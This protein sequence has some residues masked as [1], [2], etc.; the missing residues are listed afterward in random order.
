MSDYSHSVS[1]SD[2]YRGG[3]D[4][5][6]AVA[7]LAD[8]L[9]AQIDAVQGALQ[10]L[11]SDALAAQLAEHHAGVH[12]APSHHGDVVWP[13]AYAHA[14]VYD[15]PVYVHTGPLQHQHHY[16]YEGDQ[17]AAQMQTGGLS[18]PS[19]RGDSGGGGNSYPNYMNTN[20]NHA[21]APPSAYNLPFSQGG[22]FSTSPNLFTAP[23]VS[24]TTPH[25]DAPYN[26]P[27]LPHTAASSVVNP[28]PRLGLYLKRAPRAPPPHDAIIA[29]AVDVSNTIV[30]TATASTIKQW[31]TA[32]RCRGVLRGHVAS[33]LALRVYDGCLY[34]SGSDSTLIRWPSAS[35][36][37]SQVVVSAT[38]VLSLVSDT[39]SPP[40]RR[41]ATV[42]NHASPNISCPNISATATS[43]GAAATAAA[44]AVPPPPAIAPA[45]TMRLPSP[46]AF[47]AVTVAFIFVTS[48]NDATCVDAVRRDGVV[49]V[50]YRGHEAP[51]TDICAADGGGR[52][53]GVSTYTHSGVRRSGCVLYTASE[54]A[55]VRV[56]NADNGHCVS[57]LR[58]HNGP[59]RSIQL[60]VT[61][62]LIYS[63]GDDGAVRVWSADGRQPRAGGYKSTHR[64]VGIVPALDL[65]AFAVFNDDTIVTA[66]A[67]SR[68][69]AE[70]DA[71]SGTLRR[72]AQ[73]TADTHERDVW[74]GAVRDAAATLAAAGGGI[75][76]FPTRPKDYAEAAAPLGEYNPRCTCGGSGGA[77]GVCGCVRGAGGPD[78]SPVH[79]C[80]VDGSLLVAHGTRVRFL[81]LPLE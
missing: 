51:V 43:A 63:G 59:V 45:Q 16:E 76:E 49:A 41:P 14:G 21:T 42:T 77:T 13:A 80:V 68:R 39:S 58:G 46:A 47:L 5:A 9:Q 17:H 20:Y 29:V 62:G 26:T 50:T 22:G 65:D 78:E 36:M 74:D 70:W 56:W 57:V 72:T 53:N 12:P 31:T 11:Q 32:G 37:G 25:T 69:L 27:S 61:N 55:T 75:L 71:R 38:G 73:L 64:C 34:S 15:D 66:D 33:V 18:D 24:I 6:T 81:R 67:T 52:Y 30:Y 44:S 10:Q 7:A 79:L 19:A 3:G 40:R 8:N 4:G 28:T 54:D 60:T 2:I 35:P 48:P 23:G 1:P